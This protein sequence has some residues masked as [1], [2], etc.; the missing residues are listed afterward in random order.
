[1][2]FAA[3]AIFLIVLLWT[4]VSFER[5]PLWYRF[6]SGR[7]SA[8]HVVR[9]ER[10][11]DA[12]RHI[13]LQRVRYIH[14][15]RSSGV[16]KAWCRLCCATYSTTLKDA[17]HRTLLI[18]L[19]VQVFSI[20]CWLLNLLLCLWSPVMYDWLKSCRDLSA[21]PELG[22]GEQTAVAGQ[23]EVGLLHGQAQ[24]H[25]LFHWRWRSSASFCCSL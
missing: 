4:K 2:P 8:E 5:R 22:A 20:F 18:C 21:G 12:G 13:L 19:D 23:A 6:S 14:I 1:M 7:D 24:R 3:M 25:S 15:E 16:R 17:A 11:G 10:R 9:G